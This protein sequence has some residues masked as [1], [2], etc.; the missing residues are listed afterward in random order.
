M[1]WA[2]RCAAGAIGMCLMAGMARGTPIIYQETATATGSLN[3]SGFSNA[4][5]TLTA[6]TDTTTITQNGSIFSAPNLTLTG[7]ISGF[8][9][10]FTF[11]DA[12]LTVDNQGV[13]RA[14]FGD[15]SNNLAILFVGAAPFATYDL[16]TSIGPISGTPVFNPGTAFATTAGNFILNSVSTASF[17]ATLGPAAVPEPATIVS[18]GLATALCLGYARRRG[19]LGRGGRPSSPST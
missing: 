5:V 11:T 16:T 15:F 17:Q 14:G 3:G 2:R 7:T 4:M 6:A 19:R 18:A 13:S 9:G 8:G 12:T 1:S 10:S